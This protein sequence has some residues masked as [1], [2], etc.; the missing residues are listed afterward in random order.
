MTNS[1]NFFPGI[2]KILLK[3]PGLLCVESPWECLIEIILL[4]E[5]GFQLCNLTSQLLSGGL[6]IL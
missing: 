3:V 2:G 5:E 4:L 1:Y 6:G